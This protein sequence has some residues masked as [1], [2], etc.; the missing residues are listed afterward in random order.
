MLICVLDFETTGLD[1]AVN[2]P[3]ELAAA[4][5][6]GTPALTVRA[7]Y[8]TG[9]MRPFPGAILSPQAAKVHGIPDAEVLAGR[10]PAEAAREFIAWLDKHRDGKPVTMAGHF[11]SFDQG[12]MG[13]WLANAGI[14][15]GMSRFSRR[16]LDS[17]PLA[18]AAFVLTGKAESAS[19][20]AATRCLGIPHQAHRAA[21]DVSAV[22]HVMRHI[23]AK[24]AS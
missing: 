1:P 4:L 12:F 5:C 3:I 13:P 2:A 19:L 10:D 8:Q 20:E 15:G 22:I 17:M 14:D 24:H 11:V 9:I 21:G 23:L 7:T 6:E 18:M 16:M